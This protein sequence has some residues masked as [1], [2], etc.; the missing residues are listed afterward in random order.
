MK[1]STS[2]TLITAVTPMAVTALPSGFDLDRRQSGTSVPSP[3]SAQPGDLPCKPPPGVTDD[4]ADFAPVDCGEPEPKEDDDLEGE[5]IITFKGKEG[6]TVDVEEKKQKVKTKIDEIVHR[7]GRKAIRIKNISERRAARKSAKEEKATSRKGRKG[8]KGSKGEAPAEE[9]DIVERDLEGRQGRKGRKGGPDGGKVSDDPTASD[10]PPPS[11]GKD[12]PGG[13]VPPPTVDEVVDRAFKLG[14]DKGGYTLRGISKEEAQEIIDEEDTSDG[15]EVEAVANKPMKLG[16]II[17]SPD[18]VLRKRGLT[19][20]G[21]MPPDNQYKFQHNAPWGISRIGKT[22]E[23][24]APADGSLPSEWEYDEIAGTDSVVYVVDTGVSDHPD[25][26]GRRIWGENFIDQDSFDGHGHGTHVAG[27]IAGVETGIAKNATIISLKVLAANGY[28]T[29]SGVLN[30]MAWAINDAMQRPNSQGV[31]ISQ[32][33]QAILNFSL[34]GGYSHYLNE[35]VRIA[36]EYGMTCVVAA[37]NSGRPAEQY[38]PASAPEAITV[39]ATGADDVKAW[40]SNFGGAVD[41]FA[42]GVGIN[43]TWK[44]GGYAMMSGTSM[45]TPHVAGLTAYVRS[46]NDTLTTP[47]KLYDHL[48]W[49]TTPDVHQ[50]GEGSPNGLAQGE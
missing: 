24:A 7:K 50:A 44:E 45:A 39:G 43:S 47:Q 41:I 48:I 14:N 12:G 26:S 49:R 19:K 8:R 9:E 35:A 4:S 25:F 40:F 23:G 3:D 31:P 10:S 5:W 32:T 21:T 18:T 34:G 15:T 16:S 11:G 30:A 29:M 2:L 33:G 46:R 13:E 22:P 37:G 38:S 6:H 42:P 20:K 17:T 36:R 27:I 28:G 1:F